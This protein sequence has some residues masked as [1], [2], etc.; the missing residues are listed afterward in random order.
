MLALLWVVVAVL[1]ILWILGLTAFHL[2]A[3]LWLFLVAAMVVAIISLFT[4]GIFRS[5]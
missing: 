2:G 4:G 5:T 3:L 1:L